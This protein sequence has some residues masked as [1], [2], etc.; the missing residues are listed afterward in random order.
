MLLFCDMACEKGLGFSHI[1]SLGNKADIHENE[2]MEMLVSDKDITAIALY[3]EEFTDGKEFVTLVQ[4]AKKPVL[5]IAPGSSEKAREAIISHTGSLASSFDTT[6]AAV[7]KSNMIFTE[8]SQELFQLMSLVDSGQ[9][10]KGKKGGIVSNA[11]GPG[12]IAV[13]RIEAEGLELGQINEN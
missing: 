1:I 6:I 5:I 12:I 4:K 9:L 3:L 2:L 8:N 13:D 7:K 11:G 10:P